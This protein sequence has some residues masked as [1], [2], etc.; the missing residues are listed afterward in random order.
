MP[1]LTE[2]LAQQLNLEPMCFASQRFFG[3]YPLAQR[4]IIETYAQQQPVIIVAPTQYQAQ[5]IYER[6]DS[7]Q[8]YLFAADE[9]ITAQVMAASKDL[10][11]QRLLT[12]HAIQQTTRPIVVTHTSGICKPIIAKAQWQSMACTLAVGQ[13]YDFHTFLAKLVTLGYTRESIVEEIGTFSVRGGI[14]DIFP[15]H[16]EYPVRIEFF[17]DEIESIRQ[18]DT[19]TQRTVTIVETCELIPAVETSTTQG[20]I[21]DY[22]AE[23]QIILVEEMKVQANYEHMLEDAKNLVEQ[24]ITVE[25]LFV[26]LATQIGNDYVCLTKEGKNVDEAGVDLESRELEYLEV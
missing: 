15:I 17:D 3:V 23:P 9:F 5:K 26:D 2:F 18:F 6:L 24:E 12:L 16:E 14:V 8:A 22:L 10:L 13:M 21:L 19:Q 25:Q 11:V 4:L 20:T 7:Q 1:Q